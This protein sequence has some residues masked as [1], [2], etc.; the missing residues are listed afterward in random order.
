MQ[1]SVG[2]GGRIG[3]VLSV[4]LGGDGRSWQN[5]F[6]RV[7]RGVKSKQMEYRTAPILCSGVNWI[8]PA[9]GARKLEGRSVQQC[10]CNNSQTLAV[11]KHSIALR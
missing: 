5:V 2:S 4:G 9:L 1:L 11:E 10:G 3:L 8:Q 7:V 6:R